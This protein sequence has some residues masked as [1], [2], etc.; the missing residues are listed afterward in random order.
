[1]R[2]DAETLKQV[3]EDRRVAAVCVVDELALGLAQAVRSAGREDHF[4]V[5]SFGSPDATIRAELADP[6]TCMIGLVDLHPERY[7]EKLLDVCLRIK[8]ETGF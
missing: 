4:A 6:R 3:R 5:V 2:I 1:M 8:A 7:G